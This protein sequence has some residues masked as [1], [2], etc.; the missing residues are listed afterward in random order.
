[1]PAY[2]WVFLCSLCWI[3]V[4]SLGQPEKLEP[5]EIFWKDPILVAHRGNSYE[6]VPVG[7]EK[8]GD[9]LWQIVPTRFREDARV[10]WLFGWE[11]NRLYLGLYRL[12]SKWSY[13]LQRMVFGREPDKHR[14]EDMDIP[15]ADMAK[16]R[17]LVVKEL[18]ERFAEGDAGDW[19][20]TVLDK[21]IEETSYLCVQN[22][23][24]VIA[25]IS[26]VPL[27]VAVLAMV[28]K[29]GQEANPASP[30]SENVVAEKT[31]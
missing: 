20:G 1:M 9:L 18:N 22:F 3:V 15:A 12:R 10:D 5:P 26:L 8:K 17:A 30:P 25:Y 13:T 6:Y 2:G 4:L 29:P 16:I 19:F 21:G 24:L 28:T 11:D 31:E 7:T 14:P 27:I 23:A